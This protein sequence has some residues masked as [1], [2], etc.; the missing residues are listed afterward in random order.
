MYAVAAVS[1]TVFSQIFTS[2]YVYMPP[3]R[4]M[5]AVRVVVGVAVRLVL[6]RH[7]N[8]PMQYHTNAHTSTPAHVHTYRYQKSLECDALQLLYHTS[9]MIAV[10]MLCLCPM[11]DDIEVSK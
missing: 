4:A 5:V 9:P 8:I 10:G 3:M 11:F 2:K 7:T 1:F 6:H